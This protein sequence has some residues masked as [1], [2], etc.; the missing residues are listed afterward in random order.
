MPKVVHK[1]LND[2]W[3][4]FVEKPS[5][6]HYIVYQPGSYTTWLV[7]RCKRRSI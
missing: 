2:I 1:F 5:T 7:K 4:M 3:V 6:L